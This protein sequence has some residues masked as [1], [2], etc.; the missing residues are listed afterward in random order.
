MIIIELDGSQH[1]ENTKQDQ[2]RTDFLRS[3]GFRVLRFWNN[4]VS[5]NINGVLITI[6]ETLNGDYD[7]A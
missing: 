4:E 2:E 1:L 3:K 6:E 5:N 7:N